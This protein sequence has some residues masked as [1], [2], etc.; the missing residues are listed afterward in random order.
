ML[1]LNITIWS[2]GMRLILK[3]NSVRFSYDKTAENLKQVKGKS[4]NI[5]VFIWHF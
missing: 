5:F 4:D 2:S 1:Y 3:Q